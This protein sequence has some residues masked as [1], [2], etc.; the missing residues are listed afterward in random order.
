M[1]LVNALEILKEKGIKRMVGQVGEADI[2]RYIQN[3][4]DC[5]QEARDVLISDPNMEWARYHIE[6]E[7]NFF[8]IEV[9]G[10]YII[11]KTCENSLNPKTT[12]DL[13]TYGSDYETEKEMQADFDEW[14]LK[15]EADKIADK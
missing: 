2:D 8:I 3:V 11:A 4:K 9:N 14:S 6:H 1:T 15:R 10:H 12:F 7:D 13:A 5:D